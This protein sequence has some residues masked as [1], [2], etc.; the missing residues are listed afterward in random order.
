MFHALSH[1]GGSGACPCD[2]IQYP[3]LLICLKHFLPRTKGTVTEATTS[4]GRSYLFYHIL[5]GPSI[6]LGM[7]EALSSRLIFECILSSLVFQGSIPVWVSWTPSTF[8]FLL[9]EG[10]DLNACAGSFLLPVFKCI[11]WSLSQ[12][13][14]WYND[15][16]SVNYGIILSQLGSA[17]LTVALGQNTLCCLTSNQVGLHVEQKTT[18]IP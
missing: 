4:N 15:K 5:D 18:R 10:L 2:C 17:S 1:L 16:Y 9:K 7:L 11:S 3:L 13:N 12:S 6:E 14:E 8:T